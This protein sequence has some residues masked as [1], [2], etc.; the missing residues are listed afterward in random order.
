MKLFLLVVGFIV[1]GVI[2]AAVQRRFSS[3]TLANGFMDIEKGKE[4]AP[5]VFTPTQTESSED[6]RS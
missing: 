6:K 2:V 4:I 5:S 3:E 1:L